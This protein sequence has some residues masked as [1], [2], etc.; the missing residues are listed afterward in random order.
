MQTSIRKAHAGD[1]ASAWEIRNAAILSQCQAH[2]PAELLEVWTSGEMTEQF[3]RFVVEHFY[4]ATVRDE[5]VGSGAV[6]LGSG[7]LDGLFVRPDM[8]GRGV[9]RQIVAHLEA[10]AR[11]AGLTRLTLDA[12]LNAAGFYRRCGFVGETV[13]AYHSPRG[14]TLQCIPMVKRL[15]PP[16]NAG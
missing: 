15:V 16:A 9:G 5:V 11:A 2:Y 8:M 1:A 10:A 3:V 4:V 6:D 12:T 13:G 7:K 14:I